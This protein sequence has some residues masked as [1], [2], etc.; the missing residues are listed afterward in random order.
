[1]EFWKVGKAAR[2]IH[3]GHGLRLQPSEFTAPATIGTALSNCSR[4]VCRIPP[5]EKTGGIH[6]E[7]VS[8]SVLLSPL[9]ARSADGQATE[10]EVTNK[11]SEV[12]RPSAPHKTPLPA[13]GRDIDLEF[14]DRRTAALAIGEKKGRPVDARDLARRGRTCRSW[15]PRTPR[16]GSILLVVPLARSVDRE[17]A[18]GRRGRLRCCRDGMIASRIRPRPFT[19]RTGRHLGDGTFIASGLS[20]SARAVR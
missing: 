8:T 6:T 9:G 14:V 19:A 12:E 20:L 18:G 10:P 11:T 16:R 2:G 5:I 4:G 15:P 13:G 17:S 1:M 3:F 7:L